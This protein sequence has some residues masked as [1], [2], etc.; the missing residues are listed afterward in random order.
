LGSLPE[1]RTQETNAHYHRVQTSN[2]RPIPILFATFAAV[3]AS[4]CVVVS[5]FGQTSPP[6]INVPL[7]VD[8]LMLSEALKS[9][10]YTPN[11]RAQLWSGSNDCEYLYAENPVFSRAGDKV[12]LETAGNLSIGVPMGSECLSPI[13][14]QGF[15]QADTV[16]YVSGHFLK[17]RV[18]NLNLLNAQHQKTLIAGHGFDLVKQY[19]IPQLQG[20]EFD[21]DPA[22]KQLTDLAEAASPPPVAERIKTTLASLKVMPE[23][24]A[25]DRGIGATVQLTLPAL[26][27]ASA[28]PAPAQLTPQEL[29]AFE[30]TVDQWDAFLVF[31]IKQLGGMSNDRKFR[32]ALLDLLLD[33]R[34][35]LV[36]A[37]A[38]PNTGGPDP[39]RVLFLDVW[40]RLGEIVRDAAL[41]GTLGNRSLEF[42]SFISAGDA[43]FALDKAAP[44]LGM[45]I[46]ADDLRRLAHIMAPMAKGDPLAFSFD[47]DPELRKMFGVKPPLESPGPLETGPIEAPTAIPSASPNASPAPPPSPTAPSSAP[48]STTQ[49]PA[50]GPTS[51][52]SAIEAPRLDF[53]LWQIGLAGDAYAA[54]AGQAKLDIARTLREL[55]RKLRRVVVRNDN[56]ERYRAEMDQLLELAMRRELSEEDI[57]SPHRPVFLKLGKAVAWQESCWRQFRVRRNRVVYLE[58][59]SHDVGLMQVNKYVWR[60]FYSIP[61]LEWDV[62]YN[63]GAGMEILAWL[64]EDIGNKRGA[65]TP[66]KPDELAR[67]TYAAYNGGPASYRR[68]RGR[69][70]RSE[71]LIDRLFWQK[72]QAVSRGQKIDILTCAAEWER[73]PGH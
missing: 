70:S 60:G 55:G 13:S 35:R 44:A 62:I 20:F 10:V 14:W 63:A 12:R 33:S 71:R 68:W 59:S 73:T 24:A 9:Q 1:T 16:P 65:M 64:F 42:L 22:T 29:A 3:V 8:Y 41:R 38:H 47:E 25:L 5:A 49:V 66:G 36:D 40:A 45:R 50:T 23:V 32:A 46:S 39:V 19:F 48:T 43:L 67:S 21:L 72:Y 15:I 18:T 57:D 69:E 11:G 17:F 27:T 7:T 54:E 51:S 53:R 52:R 2:W 30:K 31:S 6:T 58:S 61:R 26:P 28:A 4:P 37:L 34:H 56:A